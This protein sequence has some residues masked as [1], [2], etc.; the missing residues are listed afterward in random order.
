MNR[1]VL[2]GAAGI[3]AACDGKAFSVTLAD[4][5]TPLGET[6]GAV[7]LSGTNATIHVSSQNVDG[8]LVDSIA[9]TIVG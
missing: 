2:A 1:I 9:V 8:E 6:T 4:D 7:S 5:T 3:V